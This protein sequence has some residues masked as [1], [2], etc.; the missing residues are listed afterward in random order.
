MRAYLIRRLLLLVPT[1][2]GV[3]L[4]VFLMLRLT[5]GDPVQIML[6]EFGSKEQVERLRRELGLDQPLPLQY[7][8]FIARAARGDLGVSIRSRS[9]VATEIGDRL[10]ATITLTLAATALAA[11]VGV[12]IGTVAATARYPMVDS[13]VMAF[14]LIGLSMP[15]FWSGLLL[16]LTFSLKLGWLPITESE[17]VAALILP[18]VTLAAPASAVLARITRSS[19][20]EVL[21]QEFIRTARSKG[22]AHHLVVVR[23]ALRN[24]LIP[25]L[26][27]LG[28]QFGALLAGAVI[29]ESVFARPGLGR[30]AVN[31]IL[32]RDFP[33]A[34][35]IVLIVGVMY[36]FVN[37]TIDLLY[38]FL[39]PRI[40]YQ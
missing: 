31:A 34:Q 27:I 10:P 18:A 1:L 8:R 37:A 23:H 3:T 29:V 7:V 16:I 5:P 19:V 14:S 11:T 4:A 38:G 25:V 13:A 2:F 28:L 24:A 15:T 32:S 35:G 17:G 6:G 39:D 9:P 22:V 20:L 12:S 21:R 26:T 33:L 30:L 40:R 36:V